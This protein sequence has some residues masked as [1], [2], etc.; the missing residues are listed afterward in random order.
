M[1]A[2]E[3]TVEELL[4]EQQKYERRAVIASRVAA[5]AAIVAVLAF[6]IDFIIHTLRSQP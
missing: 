1:K 5:I 6:G 4:A 2:R 3:M